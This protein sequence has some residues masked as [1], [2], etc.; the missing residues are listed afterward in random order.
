[1]TAAC[2]RVYRCMGVDHRTMRDFLLD[3]AE[4]AWL[5]VTLPLRKLVIDAM[6]EVL[7]ARGDPKEPAAFK[8]SDNDDDEPTLPLRMPPARRLAERLGLR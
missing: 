6:Q 8:W 2:R 3:A 7:D 5:V 4:A 1:M